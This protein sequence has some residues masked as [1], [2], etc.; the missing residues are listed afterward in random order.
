MKNMVAI[1]ATSAL[2]HLDTSTFEDLITNMF[3]KKGDKVVEMNIQA[4][5]HHYQSYK[6]VV[7]HYFPVIQSH[8]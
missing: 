5:K 1:G 7:L 2:M 8:H 3:T 4:L 6:D